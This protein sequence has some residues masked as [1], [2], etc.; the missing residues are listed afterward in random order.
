MTTPF[1]I[2]L[3]KHKE[4]RL[5]HTFSA[6]FRKGIKTTGGIRMDIGYTK[7]S[8]FVEQIG[9]KQHKKYF[10]RKFEIKKSLLMFFSY[11]KS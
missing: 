4:Q 7:K 8:V 10:F 11:Q 1:F 3:Q 5:S 9:F 6:A 2:D